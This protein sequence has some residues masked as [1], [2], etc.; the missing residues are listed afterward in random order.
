MKFQVHSKSINEHES[1]F[2]YTITLVTLSDDKYSSISLMTHKGEFE[3]FK[4]GQKYDMML[5]QCK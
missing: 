1:G 2:S 5:E 3:S 4:V